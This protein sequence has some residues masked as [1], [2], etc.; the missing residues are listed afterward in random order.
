MPPGMIN[1]LIRY[2]W[3]FPCTCIG[4]VFLLFALP[5]GGFSF[6]QVSLRHG[7]RSSGLSELFPGYAILWR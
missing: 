4:I 6:I 1:T 2:L 3:A 5:G 7:G